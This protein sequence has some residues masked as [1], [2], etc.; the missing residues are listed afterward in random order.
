MA[1]RKTSKALGERG[2]RSKSGDDPTSPGSIGMGPM[3]GANLS[4][5]KRKMDEGVAGPSAR[6]YALN[7]ASASS[8]AG[9]P[10]DVSSLLQRL[11][12]GVGA[13]PALPESSVSA[14]LGGTNGNGAGG[15]DLASLLQW[16][17]APSPTALLLA[18]AQQ[19]Q[20][21]EALVRGF[22]QQPG[23]TASSTGLQQQ[24]LSSN[25]QGG[26]SSL[27]SLLSA[28]APAPPPASSTPLADALAAA[29]SNRRSAA[30]PASNEQLMDI[31]L[32]R[33]IL[34]SASSNPPAA[35]SAHSTTSSLEDLLRL[36]QL[37]QQQLQQALGG[38]EAKAAEVTRETATMATT[39][40]TRTQAETFHLL[41]L[42]NNQN[43]LL[44][45]QASDP[46][47]TL[48]AL[49]RTLGNSSY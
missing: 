18:Q 10:T 17:Q 42:L 2:K 28:S 15:I 36:R 34:S 16:Q 1:C 3:G 22:L 44:Q 7:T 11:T 39:S 24:L 20:Q 19:Q 5:N 4:G 27:A 6:N 45:Q 14:L 46:A 43:Q 47:A 25:A 48:A 9:V 12:G 8:V 37:Q 13:A 35:A 30:T 40:G 49:R 23:V 29:M 38:E 33:H 26:A 31:A 32:A 21:R 41:Q